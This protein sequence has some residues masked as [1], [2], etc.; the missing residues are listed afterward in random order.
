M[1]LSRQKRRQGRRATGGR[2]DGATQPNAC[3]LGDMA[4]EQREPAQANPE[5]PSDALVLRRSL[6]TSALLVLA[7]TAALGLVARAVAAGEINRTLLGGAALVAAFVA[8]AA[9]SRHGSA[10]TLQVASWAL[11]FLPIALL[12]VPLL[13][14][15]GLHA[16]PLLLLAAQ[17]TLA[18]VLLGARAAVAAFLLV[19]AEGAGLLALHAGGY[20]FAPPFNGLAID[21]GYLVCLL[22]SSGLLALM[23]WRLERAGQSARAEGHT[24]AEARRQEGESLKREFEGALREAHGFLELLF[25]SAPLPILA[26]DTQT[27]ISRWNPA[28]ERMFG[29][30]QAEA[31]N[32][33][34]RL[35]LPE[36]A[37][38]VADGVAGNPSVNKQ[39]V[40]LGRMGQEIAV[41]VSANTLYDGGG[42]SIGMLAI[43]S[44]VTKQREVERQL[45]MAKENAEQ[46]AASKSLF[47]A[48]MSHEIR[49]PLHGLLGLLELLAHAKL[50]AEEAHFLATAR[51]SGELL[52]AIL[53]DI[54]DFSKMDAGRLA[55]ETLPFDLSQLLNDIRT[56]YARGHWPPEVA[57]SVDYQGDMTDHVVG[58]EGRLRQVLGNLLSNARKFTQRGSVSLIVVGRTEGEFSALTFTVRDTGIGMSPGVIATLFAPFTQADVSTSRRYGG[59]GLGLSICRGLVMGMGG[60]LHVSSV[61]EQGSSFEFTLRLPMAAAPILEVAAS[62]KAH[63]DATPASPHRILVAEDN[64]VNQLLIR[65][66]LKKLGY[67]TEVVGDGGAAVAAL[68]KRPSEFALVIMDCQMPEMD[69]YEACRRIRGSVD[70]HVRDIPVIAMTANAM[71]SDEL[72]CR[73]AGMNDY[74]TKPLTL[75]H[76]AAVLTRWLNH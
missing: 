46:V 27:N 29:Y 50:S 52:S 44:D 23:S 30:A 47:L 56:S 36:A 41:S 51:R 58:D 20:P 48:N 61:E 70:P 67:Q 9:A 43:L 45:A 14:L 3:T 76:L 60:E 68:S 15:G 38:L 5:V 42:K 32:Q 66:Q 49:T 39:M 26:V 63:V 4:L 54:L 59:T 33:P 55:F 16:P 64:A 57:F 24:L 12:P 28:C 17:P 8:L 53:N 73:E 13:Q 10:R 65:S 18:A 6:M 71:H 1:P 75:E 34:V 22:G 69:G 40:G 2:A 21:V 19:A 31:I 72:L 74:V 35:V 25:D 11:C 62:A 37:T 7:A